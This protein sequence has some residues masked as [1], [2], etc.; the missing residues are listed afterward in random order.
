MD[1]CLLLVHW[2]EV[3]RHLPGCSPALLSHALHRRLGTEFT[4][5]R[6]LAVLPAT[7]GEEL[8]RVF[9]CWGIECEAP[10]RHHSLE[11]LLSRRQITA[12]TVLAVTTTTSGEEAVAAARGLGARVTIWTPEATAGAACSG[13]ELR[14]LQD[15]LHL[16]TAHPVGLFVDWPYVLRTPQADGDAPRTTLAYRLLWAARLTGSLVTARFFG[17]DGCPHGADL[18]GVAAAWPELSVNASEAEGPMRAELEALLDDPHA[19]HTWILTTEAPWLPEL[20]ERARSRGIRVLWW[21]A[22][23]AGES[24]PPEWTLDG[25]S[26]LSPLLAAPAHPDAWHPQAPIRAS[27]TVVRARVEPRPP[28][29]TAPA[30]AAPGPIPADAR[31]GPWL[32]LLFYTECALRRHGWSRISLRRLAAHLAESEEFGPTTAN[33]LVWLNR[34]RDEGLLLFDQETRSGEISHRVTVCHPNPEHPLTRTSVEVPDRCLRL[35]RQMLHRMPW[36][37]FKLLRNVLLR[38]QWLG[39]PPY[40]LDEAAVDEW[41]NFLIQCS[42]VRMSKEPNIENPEYPVTALRLNEQ[43]PVARA[44]VPTPEEARRLGAERAVLAID[45]FLIRNR[46]PWMAMGALRR[47][48]SAI[49]REELQTLLQGLQN[50]GALVTESYPNPQK[51]HAT[52]GC[53]LRRDE[54]FVKG[55]LQTRDLIVSVAQGQQQGRGWIP[56]SGLEAELDARLDAAPAERRAW[57]RLLRDEGLLELD[58]E[59][60]AEEDEPWGDTRCRLNAADPVVRQI[61]G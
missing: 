15:E 46:K 54:P 4:D 51:E 32:R 33:S 45:H 11:E 6:G 48:L 28:A 26:D 27:Q 9:E 21:R 59:H 53:R 3:V 2:A 1:S 60:D 42:A 13:A 41:L 7:A 49:H 34:A 30:G 44:Y 37:S 8:R 22:R 24:A 38:E 18:A 5:L 52:T 19:P 56:L 57:I 55:T 43:H 17:I 23:P 36:V 35:L 29:G 14:R 16:E 50:L 12:N 31:L 10:E 40:F 47:S 25:C 20:A 39:G 58:Q 61:V